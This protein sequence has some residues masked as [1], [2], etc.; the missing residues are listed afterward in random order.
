MTE[1][2]VSAAEQ[3]SVTKPSVVAG[4]GYPADRKEESPEPTGWLNNNDGNVEKI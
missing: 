2:E 3:S 4:L 1:K